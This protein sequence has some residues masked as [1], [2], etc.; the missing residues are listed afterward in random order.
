MPSDASEGGWQDQ[1]LVRNQDQ[2]PLVKDLID[3]PGAPAEYDVLVGY[4]G[5]SSRRAHI[6]VYLGLDLSGWVD[7]PTTAVKRM[8]R[9]SQDSLSPA[10]IWVTRGT[11]VRPGMSTGKRA[12]DFLQGAITLEQLQKAA[13]VSY[14]AFGTFGGLT[15]T[16]VGRWTTLRS[17]K[18]PPPP[19][20]PTGPAED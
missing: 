6:R 7:V 17:P 15:D 20:P 1:S 18:P 9:L 14:D 2:H 12:E 3:D 5:K 19:P 16:P 8:Q 10:V 13:A 4:N 11:R